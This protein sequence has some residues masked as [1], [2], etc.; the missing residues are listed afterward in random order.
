MPHPNGD[1]GRSSNGRGGAQCSQPR[2]CWGDHTADELADRSSGTTAAA[3]GQTFSRKQLGLSCRLSRQILRPAAAGM[4][5]RIDAPSAV[6]VAGLA[7]PIWWLATPAAPHNLNRRALRR[8]ASSIAQMRPVPGRSAAPELPGSQTN[9][10]K[11]GRPSCA[12]SRLTPFETG[13]VLLRTGLPCDE[14]HMSTPTVVLLYTSDT[15]EIGAHEKMPRN[16]LRLLWNN[17]R[18]PTRQNTDN[19][20]ETFERFLADPE[21]S[22][23]CE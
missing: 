4:R 15:L 1:G 21:G 19:D 20:N 2:A 9:E 5:R 17:G 14:V 7:S 3:S 18:L 16:D 23:A 10:A 11:L 8:P 22:A 12:F 13:L 6:R